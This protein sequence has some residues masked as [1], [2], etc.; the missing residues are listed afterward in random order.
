MRIPQRPWPALTGC[1]AASRYLEKFGLLLEPLPSLEAAVLEVLR[2]DTERL[3]HARSMHPD[4]SGLQ[5]RPLLR[6]ATARSA[7]LASVSNGPTSSPCAGSVPLTNDGVGR[8]PVARFGWWKRGYIRLAGISPS[9][10]P[11]SDG[12]RVVPI[13]AD[14]VATTER[15]TAGSEMEEALRRTMTVARLGAGEAYA[16]LAR[17]SSVWLFPRLGAGERSQ[18][19]TPSSRPIRWHLT[20][21]V[22]VTVRAREKAWWVVVVVGWGPGSVVAIVR[23]GCRHSP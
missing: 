7:P 11:H 13:D 12:G 20:V 14:R 2:R 23:R 16:Q 18:P 5:L 3:S 21:G 15:L 19:S 4:F 6:P 8:V 17:A 9:S 1:H 22:T 10:A